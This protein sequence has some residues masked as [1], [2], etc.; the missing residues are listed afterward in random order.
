MNGISHVRTS[1]YHPT[2]N[3]LA[4]RAIQTFKAAMK[5]MNMGTIESRVPSFLFKY[6]VM[7]HSTTGIPP[8]ELM[9][10]RQL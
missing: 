3:G 10:N 8:A 9:F 4:E 7:P 6:R 5:R 2:S 1:P